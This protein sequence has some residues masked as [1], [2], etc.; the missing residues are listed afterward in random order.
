MPWPG[1]S[2]HSTCGLSPPG[3]CLC[4][5][6]HVPPANQP[7]YTARSKRSHVLPDGAGKIPI[8]TFFAA[9]LPPSHSAPPSGLSGLLDRVDSSD[10]L[11][12]AYMESFKYLF[13]TPSPLYGA[14]TPDFPTRRTFLKIFAYRQCSFTRRNVCEHVNGWCISYEGYTATP[15]FRLPIPNF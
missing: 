11:A 7:R 14:D 8:L 2:R 10:W 4:S 9:F 3:M 1:H 13:H 15:H 5:L 6:P 12:C